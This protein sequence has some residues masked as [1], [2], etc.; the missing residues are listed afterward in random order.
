MKNLVKI[1][2]LSLLSYAG[3]A[4]SKID[5]R[6]NEI[7]MDKP[8]RI[9]S[10]TVVPLIIN[11][12]GGSNSNQMAFIENGIF[13]GFMGSFQ[14]GLRISFKNGAL[15][16]IG[17]NFPFQRTV[18]NQEGLS[19]DGNL[20]SSNLGFT[21][22]NNA[23]LKP[24]FAD[25]DGKLIV[26][27]ATTHYGSYNFTAV[28]AQDWDDQLRKGSGF[29]WF[30]TTN[31]PKTMY[32]PVNLPD[33][34]KITGVQMSY[35]DDSASSIGFTFNANSHNNNTFTTICSGNSILAD[36]TM[37]S[38]F[39]AANTIVDNNV[40]S[41]YVNISSTGNWTGNTLRFHSLVIFYQYQ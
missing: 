1:L 39:T 8:L 26:D 18:I 36:D 11:T 14:D 16:E 29:A 22:T 6:A 25:K 27:N 41:Y 35:I 21:T 23:Q 31:A 3:F 9:N 24:V 12:T 13:K 7:I 32:L 40:N 19:V 5:M 15:F 34:V 37:R 20:K 33:G 4:Q 17:E 38:S 10:P 30:N 2:I 28:Q